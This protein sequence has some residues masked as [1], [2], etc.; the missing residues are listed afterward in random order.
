MPTGGRKAGYATKIC[1][2]TGNRDRDGEMPKQ[3]VCYKAGD[4]TGGPDLEKRK[5]VE[6]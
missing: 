5:R 4:E 2:V 6:I 3:E 1:L